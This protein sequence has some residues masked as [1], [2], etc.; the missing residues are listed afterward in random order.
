MAGD[1]PPID[2]GHASQ[3]L[4]WLSGL[5]TATVG[6]V[7]LWLAQRVL[8]KAAF[9]SAISDGFNKLTDQ[10][11]EER[12]IERATFDAERKGWASERAAWSAE[13]IAW[14]A[15][16]ATLKGEVRNLRQVIDGLERRFGIE[17]SGNPEL[18]AE[19]GANPNPEGMP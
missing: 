16:R 15:E 11:Q 14:A 4:G 5:A 1:V 7:G 13:R 19:P 3:L 9:Q 18:A 12:A 6:A 10:L 8:G 17:P 2:P